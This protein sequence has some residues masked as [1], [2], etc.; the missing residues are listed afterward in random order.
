[1]AKEDVFLIRRA[2]PLSLNTQALG[3]GLFGNAAASPSGRYLK[4]ESSA[5]ERAASE[6]YALRGG[7]LT[8]DRGSASENLLTDVSG[9]SSLESRCG[10]LNTDVG[11]IPC[12]AGDGSWSGSVT[13]DGVGGGHDG[14]AGNPRENGEP[15]STRDYIAVISWAGVHFFR[16]APGGK[17]RLHRVVYRPSPRGKRT[18]SRRNNHSFHWDLLDWLMFNG[19]L[20]YWDL[21]A[22][23]AIGSTATRN[24]TT[25]RPSVNW[26]DV[27]GII[28]RSR[29]QR[30][31]LPYG[32]SLDSLAP[33]KF[34]T[35]EG[36]CIRKHMSRVCGYFEGEANL[37]GPWF[38]CTEQRG[39]WWQSTMDVFV[40]L[41]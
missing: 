28:L 15:G 13:G 20:D 10:S 27:R 5:G 9:D 12:G 22:G 29:L 35:R 41:T 32:E 25:T 39:R 2:F 24:H 6:L 1:M 26:A 23:T 3:E 37:P 36:A 8:R 11:G 30:D 14:V 21:T 7:G 34:S 4:G 17:H 33:A 38:E 31:D 18:Q 40:S 16:K 19:N